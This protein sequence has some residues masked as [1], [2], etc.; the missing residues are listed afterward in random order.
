[1][2]AEIGFVD[3]DGAG[4]RRVGFQGERDSPPSL[5]EN[6]VDGADRNG[7]QFSGVRSRKIEGE[8]SDNLPEFRLGNFS[9]FI[10]PVFNNYLSK[11]A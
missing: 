4:Q 1:M 5:E 3:F 7:G 8:T 11:L 10:A 6:G 2:G 9:T